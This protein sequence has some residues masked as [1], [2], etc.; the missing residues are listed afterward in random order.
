MSPLPCYFL[1]TSAV[2]PAPAHAACWAARLPEPG[3]AD[4]GLAVGGGQ[5]ASCPLPRTLVRTE[6]ARWCPLWPSTRSLLPR[7]L[8][9]AAHAHQPQGSRSLLG[10][11][12]ACA[13]RSR[14]QHWGQPPLQETSHPFLAPLPAFRVCTSTPLMVAPVRWP[15]RDAQAAAL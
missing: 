5:R 11:G 13:S 3:A 15:P 6:L 8:S 14:F 2:A 1:E 7:P 4:L 12:P 10:Q 9:P